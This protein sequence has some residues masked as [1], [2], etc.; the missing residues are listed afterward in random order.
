MYCKKPRQIRA[1]MGSSIYTLCQFLI[2]SSANYNEMR[3]GYDTK[4]VDRQ[5]MIK[6]KRKKKPVKKLLQK[7]E[8][9]AK[10][11]SGGVVQVI[12]IIYPTEKE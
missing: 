9:K 8:V 2:K 3:R 6:K 1:N 10:A 5:P 12:T 11:R 7:R 4:G